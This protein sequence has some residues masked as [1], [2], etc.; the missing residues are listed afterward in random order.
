MSVVFQSGY[1]LPGGD[2]PLTHSRVLHAG[3]AMPIRSASASSEGTNFPATAVKN[4]LTV[5]RWRP[6]DNVVQ[7]PSD[8]SDTNY[9]TPTRFIVGADGQTLDEGASAGV[10]RY[11]TQNITTTAGEYVFGV[12]IQRQTMTG[13][14]LVMNDGTNSYNAD[15]NLE[16]LSVVAQTAAGADIRELPNGDIV[17]RIYN[18]LAAGAGYVRITGFDVDVNNA[19]YTG[20]NR[21]VRVLEAM[22]HLSSAWVRIDG[23][24]AVASDVICIAAHNLGS[25]IARLTLEHDANEDDVWTAIDVISPADDS[26]I[27]FFFAPITSRRW[28]L[29]VDR[30]VMPEIAV[31]R[32]GKAL[33]FERPFYGNYTPAAFNR[34]VKILGNYSVTGELLGRSLIRVNGE[35]TYKWNNLTESWVRANLVGKGKLIQS[36]EVEPLFIAWRPGEAAEA[37]FVMK[38]TVDPPASIGLRDLWSF[39]FSGE[40]YLDA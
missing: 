28:R 34:Q 25:S 36:I 10:Y 12:R 8:L 24:S 5:D 18:T 35:T 31:F 33:Q 40:V 29:T 11:I 27:M 39:G 16:T 9:W 30:G 15:F 32:V 37:D 20:T 17:L 19:A 1:T 23:F 26:T 3:I 21:T 7:S 38:A 14:R 4:S 2:L 13:L 6:F 22:A